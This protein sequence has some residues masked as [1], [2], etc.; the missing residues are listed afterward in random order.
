MI[1]ILWIQYMYSV[2]IVNAH[3]TITPHDYQSWD[4]S[5]KQHSDDISNILQWFD[6]Q[7]ATRSRSTHTTKLR[8]VRDHEYRRN[9]TNTGTG[10]GTGQRMT[11]NSTM[12][13]NTTTIT[14]HRSLFQQ[15]A[16]EL[17][18]IIY[19]FLTLKEKMCIINQLSHEAHTSLN[20]LSFKYGSLPFNSFYLQRAIQIIFSEKWRRRE[21][22]YKHWV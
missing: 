12:Q 4:V 5:I 21:N 11:I 6:G 9:T 16:K 18:D 3:C 2:C 8:T 19:Q 1:I 15:G 14:P 7:K 17:L 22:W 10:T 13:S 20:P